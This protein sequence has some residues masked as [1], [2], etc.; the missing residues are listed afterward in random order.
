MR[1]E[2]VKLERMR[3]SKDVSYNHRAEL[4]FQALF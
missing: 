3:Y 1:G 2:K 4:G